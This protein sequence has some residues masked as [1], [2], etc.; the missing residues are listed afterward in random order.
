MIQNVDLAILAW[1][2]ETF[3]C[4]PLDIAATQITHLG[5]GGIF[6]IILAALCLTYKPTRRL[7]VVLAVSMAFDFLLCN[8]TVKPLVNRVR[9]YEVEDIAL[10][11]AP[12]HDASFPSGHTAI[13]FAFAWVMVLRRERFWK[14]ALVLAVLIGLSRLYLNVHFPSDVLCGALFGM[15]AAHFA[16]RVVLKEKERLSLCLKQLSVSPLSFG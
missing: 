13:S 5:D 7:G 15:I 11:V 2:R 6:C 8:L 16:C 3:W 10:I 4:A 9:P 1:I 12:P 14:A